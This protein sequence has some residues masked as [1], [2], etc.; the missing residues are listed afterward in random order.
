MEKKINELK[1]DELKIV[2]GGISYSVSAV[3][4]ARPD[5]SRLLATASQPAMTVVYP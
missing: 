1:L 3:A 2:A 5:Y 4:I